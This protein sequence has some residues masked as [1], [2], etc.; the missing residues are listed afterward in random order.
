[1]DEENINLMDYIEIIIKKKTLILSF[2]LAGLIIAGG[3]T[4]LL[5][6]TYK[7]ETYLRIGSEKS[8]SNIAK[9]I[10]AGFLGDYPGIKATNLLETR[11]VK[12]EI[13]SKNP[14]SAKKNLENINKSILEKENQEIKIK[15]KYLKDAIDKLEKKIK[16]LLYRNNEVASLELKIFGIQK[17]IDNMRP[18]KIIKKPVIVSKEKANLI[19][20]LIC[21]GLLGIFLGV[22]LAFGKEW[23]EKNKKEL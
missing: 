5:P 14:N 10:N 11:L 9:E 12:I 22:F 21:G 13:S 4:F 20:N 18:T 6:K 1:M 2:F 16:F 19:F 23:W 15:K 3:I 17:Q 7:A 8:P